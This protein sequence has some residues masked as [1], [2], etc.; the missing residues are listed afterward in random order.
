MCI[1]DR[2][3]TAEHKA[4]GI[5]DFLLQICDVLHVH[6]EN[7]A[8]FEAFHMVMVVASMVKSI[9]AAWNL[10]LSNL[11]TVGKLI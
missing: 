7:P 2:V 3:V 9:C 11:S 10:Q 1:R 4:V 5:P 8:T 6:I